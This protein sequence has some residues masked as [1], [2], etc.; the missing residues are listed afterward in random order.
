MERVLYFL[1]LVVILGTGA[2]LADLPGLE[3]IST[4]TQAATLD[5]SHGW[6]RTTQGWQHAS[7]WEHR[8]PS[9]PAVVR[10]FNPISLT[11]LQL[12]GSVGALATIP[13]LGDKLSRPANFPE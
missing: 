1:I 11:L 7:T 3:A 13:R 5:S 10:Y 12:I 9:T 6:R 4:S 8:S 2:A